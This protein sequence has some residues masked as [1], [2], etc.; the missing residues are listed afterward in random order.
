M[1]VQLAQVHLETTQEMVEQ[2]LIKVQLLEQVWVFV[3]F[4]LAVVVAEIIQDQVDVVDQVV[5]AKVV[6]LQLQQ[7]QQAQLTLVAVVAVGHITCPQQLQ[8]QVALV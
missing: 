3:E 2:A 4:L 8:H 7:G 6:K 1:L 5:E